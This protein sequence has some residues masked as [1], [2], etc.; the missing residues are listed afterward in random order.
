M[1]IYIHIKHKQIKATIKYVNFLHNPIRV[2]EN[3]L[4]EKSNI[5]RENKNKCLVYRWVNKLNGKTYIGSTVNFY[6][7]FYRYYKLDYLRKLNTPIYNALLKYGFDN[8]K[9]EILEYCDR[10]VVIYKEQ[11]YF[12]L[13]KPEYNILQ[14]A[15]SSLGFKH[16]DKTLRF[17][18]N[19]RKLD[20]VAKN[21]LSIAASN[22]ILTE[23]EKE[24]L[25]KA[26]MGIKL[27]EETRRK[28]SKS[29][30]RN[31]GVGVIVEDIVTKE[32]INY[33][34]LTE[35]SVKLGVSRTA[36]RKSCLTGNILKKR[37]IIKEK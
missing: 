31:I 19:E 36:V 35:A 9:L 32:K 11:Y 16:S 2:Y 18:K 10:K 22:R 24:N 14:I 23:L 28:I 3:S 7:R 29:T 25:S 37:Y 17:F 6:S 15:G 26:R 5:F 4:I 8:F 13:L 34:S 1:N 27:S 21:K 30:V 12:D 33:S 20:E